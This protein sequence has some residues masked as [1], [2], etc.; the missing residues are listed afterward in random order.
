ILTQPITHADF[1][2]LFGFAMYPDVSENCICVPYWQCKEDYSGL[3]EDGV[4][5]MDI[6][7]MKPVHNSITCTG[8]FDVC[9]QIEC[10]RQNTGII[11]GILRSNSS[12]SNETIDKDRAY[13]GEFPWMLGI[14]QS[15]VYK[16]GASLI[17]PQVAVTAAHCVSPSMKYVVR[18][19]EWNWETKN[20]PLPHEDQFSKKVILHP[21]YRPETLKN[22]IALLI[23][24]KPFKLSENVGV[25]CIPTEKALIT[26]NKCI[27]SGWGK[28]PLDPDRYQSVLKKVSLSIIPNH[29]CTQK[30]RRKA[31]G[32]FFKL[33]K[34]FICTGGGIKKD[35]CRGDGGGPLVCPITEESN[36]YQQ[37][38]IVSWGVTCGIRE[39]LGVYVN[40]A[41]FSDWIDKQMTYFNFDTRIY[42]S[43][44]NF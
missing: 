26:S 24:E 4:G 33:D 1:D 13:F 44:I 39:S 41:L 32:P 37:V 30:L 17:H 36:R 15:N 28:S 23:L 42:K 19:G 25:I 18:A 29:Q 14:L 22:D 8:D 27:A 20:E 2:D 11:S 7:L 5:I 12:H 10:G 3:I 40:I 43:G 16:C 34:S 31:L 21:K 9:C 38:G 6:R 35:T